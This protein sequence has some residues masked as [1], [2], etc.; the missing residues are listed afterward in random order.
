M[1]HKDIRKIP[2]VCQYILHTFIKASN[3]VSLQALN[4]DNRLC[5]NIG[6]SF[7]VLLFAVVGSEQRLVQNY[8]YYIFCSFSTQNIHFLFQS[9]TLSSFSNPSLTK[10]LLIMV[11]VKQHIYLE[12]LELHLLAGNLCLFAIDFVGRKHYF[13]YCAIY[14]TYKRQ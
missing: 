5:R 10:S 6:N 14:N 2:H 11:P 8:G 7:K 1:A 4:A 13:Y 12:N 9:A 3:N